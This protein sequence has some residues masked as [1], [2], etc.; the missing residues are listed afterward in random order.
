MPTVTVTKIGESDSR[1]VF[2]AFI[3]GDGQPD[4]AEYVL[5]APS[6][7]V[8]Q[9]KNNATAF[10]IRRIWYSLASFNAKLGFSLVNSTPVWMLTQSTSSEVDFSFFGGLNDYATVPPSDVDGK[11]WISTYGLAS[12]AQAGSLVLE[13]IKTNAL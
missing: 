4:L 1:L 2:R 7:L 3:Q 10:R 12:A 5:M 8:P 6:D 9:R 11:L 13:L